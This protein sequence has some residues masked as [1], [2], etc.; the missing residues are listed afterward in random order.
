MIAKTE[1]EIMQSWT[2]H[3]R[4]PLA[5]ICTR[6]YNLEKF[7]A[8]C[9][10]SLLAQETDFPF[11]IVID[12]DCSTDGTPAI[13]EEYAT[14]FPTIIK[15]NLRD[16]NVGLKVNLVENL[17]RAS[18]K[19]IA[20]CDGDDFWTDPKKLEAQVHF[21]ENDHDEEYVV[22]FCRVLPLYEEGAPL[23]GISCSRRDAS[24]EALQKHAA[25][26]NAS[27]VCFRN[28]DSLKYYPQE[29]L[30]AP[31]DDHFLWSFLGGFGKGKFLD[32][33]KPVMYR[34]HRG[35]DFT[36]RTYAQKVMMNLKTD[37]M[38]F[39]YHGRVGNQE[40]SRHFLRQVIKHFITLNGVTTCLTINASRV[41]Q[42]LI[43]RAKNVARYF[44]VRIKPE[45]YPCHNETRKI[46]RERL[47]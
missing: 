7:I 39:L 32:K 35:G 19:Y 42:L 23:T 31:I 33:V 27:T 20:I 36:S 9:L 30:F 46:K 41:K 14:K 6:S 3:E 25:G 15:P 1:S 38:L 17:Q 10:D 24:A 22:A 26:T 16:V 21:L 2:N 40:I 8:V 18:G 28:L 12:D 5:S 11:E 4:A 43:G 37:F 34:Q 13:I 29:Y 47:G 44:M 45:N